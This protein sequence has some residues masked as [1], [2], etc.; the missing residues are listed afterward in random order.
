MPGEQM[1]PTGS[2]LDSDFSQQD[3]PCLIIED[4]QPE[5]QVLEDDSG[6][7]LSMLSRHLPNLQTH[8]ENPVLDVVS[9]PE[10]TAGEEQG[11]NNSGFNE[12]LKENKAAE[13]VD[14]SHLD[15]CSSISQV[16]EQIPQPN[17]TSSVLGMSVESAPP[18]GEEK[19][20][21]VEEKEEEKEEDTG[22]D[23]TTHSLGA[24]DPAS[25]QLGFGVLELSQSQ[26]VEEHTLPYEVD[27]EPLLSVTTNSSYT[28]LSNMDANIGIKHEEQSNE[29]ISMAEQP[30]RDV[31]VETKTSKD[32]PGLEEQNPPSARSE[33]MPSSPKVSLAAMETNE[34][35]TAQELLQGGLKI[36]K[37]PEPEVLS[38]QED[39]FDQSNKAASGDCSTPLR[40]EGGIS[41]VSTPATTLQLLQL[42]GQR[43]LVQESLSTNSS[44]LIAPSPDA[45][46]STPFIIPS[47]PTEQEG[48]KD[49]PM[50]MTVLSE[51]KGE[52]FEKK[53]QDDEPVEIENPPVPPEPVISPQASTPVSQSTPVF[54]PGSLPIPSQPEF[55]H[56]HGE[57]HRERE[58]SR[59]HQVWSLKPDSI[60][61]P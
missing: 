26:D 3:T 39:L 51:G 28:R 4:S 5:S 25:S 55:S 24:E 52:S 29:D 40:E 15:A 42:S 21:E 7:H 11:D 34:R 58:R 50:D 19:E 54:N 13:P 6:S 17:R 49:E 48:R 43:S 56:V 1:D 10:Q 30:S 2:Q 61:R 60:S 45:F 38:T 36:Q 37:S 35:I 14:S 27:K 23:I 59:L 8:K 31:P 57:G 44:D 16:I 20:E 47:S 41:L 22:D 32:V 18:A 33:D 12:H 9:N 53:L 46:R